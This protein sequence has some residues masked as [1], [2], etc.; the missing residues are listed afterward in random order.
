MAK[1]YLQTVEK[2]AKTMQT[3]LFYGIIAR[4]TNEELLKKAR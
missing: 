3:K 4:K 2:V 1:P